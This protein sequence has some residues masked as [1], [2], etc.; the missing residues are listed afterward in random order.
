VS[1]IVDLGR[2]GDGLGSTGKTILL[3]LLNVMDGHYTTSALPA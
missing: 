3:K 1:S 2:L